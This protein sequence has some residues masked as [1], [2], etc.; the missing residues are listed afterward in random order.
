M[1]RKK[2][3]GG[4]GAVDQSAL[5]NAI[6]NTTETLEVL[7]S[8]QAAT[9]ESSASVVPEVAPVVPPTPASATESSAPA[10]A[11]ESSAPATESSAPPAT[12][13]SAPPATE[14][15]APTSAPTSAPAP[16]TESSVPATESS[17]ALAGM[18]IPYGTGLSIAYN[19]IEPIIQ[20]MINNPKLN[21]KNISPEK[22]QTLLTNIK[23][24]TNT[25]SVTNLL[26]SNGF[27]SVIGSKPINRYFS[28]GKTKKHKMMRRRMRTK[29][30]NT[31]K[32][33]NRSH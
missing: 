30:R 16:A 9:P 17:D 4:A 19:Q 21:K 18:T 33:R 6:K 14:S 31:M 29:R 32:K 11:T 13:S 12:E 8:M 3:R 15:S 5:Q 7:K 1:T 2:M 27:G 26:N 28:G 22:L 20:N 25:V 23:S 24:A 10:S